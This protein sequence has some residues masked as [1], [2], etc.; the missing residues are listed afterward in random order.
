MPSWKNMKTLPDQRNRERILGLKIDVDTYV[1]MKKG[2]PCLLATLSR[3]GF[4][5]TFY[6][7]MGPDA[8]GRAVLQLIKNPRFLRKMLRTNAGRLYGMKTVL[9]GTLLPSPMIA[10]SFPE[11][12]EQI[13]SEG[14]EVEFHAWDHRRWQDELSG[15]PLEW[16]QDW[17]KKGVGAYRKLTGGD[18]SSFGAPAWLIDDRALKIAGE[19]S[20]KYLSCTRAKAPFIHETSGLMEIPSDLPCLEETGIA[21]GVSKIIDLLSAGGMHVLPVHAEVEGGVWNRYFIE[22]L[23]KVSGMDYRVVPLSKV[24]DVLQGETLPVRKYRMELL[25]GRSVPCAV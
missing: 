3:F 13:L 11:L 1:G 20:F 9:Y 2:V 12:V 10:L 17:F 15:R 8:S 22:L 21:D 16:I 25:L 19:Y 18:P 14:H 6:L 5:G 7:S 24:W 23:E 4:K